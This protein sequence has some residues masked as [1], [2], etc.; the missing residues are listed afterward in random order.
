MLDDDPI[1]FADVPEEPPARR[2]EEPRRGRASGPEPEPPRP[3]KRRWTRFV[4]FVLIVAASLVHGWAI[5]RGLGGREGIDGA[6]V[7]WRDDHPLYFHS[8][9]AT[10]AF[11]SQSGTT[12]GYDPAFMSGYPKSVVFPASSTLPELALWAFGGERPERAFKLYILLAAAAAPWL[13]ACAGW[14]QGMGRTA[15]AAA[16]LLFVGYVWTDWP[17]N[18]VGFGMLPYFV[19]APT[20][21]V[22]A[23]MFGRFVDV[24]GFGRWLAAA[25]L[26]SAAF[27]MHL[28]AGMLV[29]PAGALAYLGVW[30]AR[31]RGGHG[32]PISRHLGVW[33][34]PIVVLALN[35]FWWAPAL[36]LGSTKGESGF[37]FFHPEGSLARITQLFTSEAPAEL[38]LL[39]LGLPGLM[40]LATKGLGRGLALAG[41][42]AA[43]WFWAYTAADVRALDFLQP[44]RH[45]FALYSALAVASG[46]AFSAGLERLR[47]GVGATG[48]EAVHLD[49]W[50][51]LAAVLIGIRILGT[52]AAASIRARVLTEPTFLSSQPPPRFFWILKRF[53]E[54]VKPGERVLYEEGGEDVPGA[55]DPFGGGRFTGLLPWKTGAELIGG[56]YLKAAL[57]ANFTQ[58]G[59]DALFG[60]KGWDRP[61]F[62]K[63][64]RLYRPS[65]I[66]CWTPHARRFCRENPDLATVL[67][68]DG[69]LLF[70]RIAGY[71]GDAIR[72][73][74]KVEAT[75]GRLVVREMVPDLDGCV[76]LRYHSVPSLQAQPA[77]PVDAE[78]AEEDPVP[79]IRVRPAAG[80]SEVTLEMAPPIRG[81]WSSSR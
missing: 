74:A 32:L 55:P 47:P 26:C 63:Y 80:A 19:A 62:E 67:D 4:P 48:A 33:T 58:F 66:L 61:F 43:G 18:Y 1:P 68:D 46:A 17:I 72:G 9:L 8:A 40:V 76:V 44:G 69:T 53:Q 29:A 39:G 71:G 27:L 38:I 65:Y 77:A 35:A 10:R 16:V 51:M 81:P 28:T 22:A 21:L 30:I 60:R 20:C 79:F 25:L 6:W 59:G 36:W 54:N 31:R 52:P 73:S 2:V 56:P 42:A 15:V 45:T 70:A 3:P 37:A 7:P 14:I 49:C 13:V 34:V 50:A 12:A 5:W 78:Y 41:V 11:L 24:G 57:K 23:G 64:A 75:P